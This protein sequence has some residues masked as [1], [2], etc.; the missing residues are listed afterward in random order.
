MM[1]RRL[2]I[3]V[4]IFGV[5]AAGLVAGRLLWHPARI[6][7]K[8]GREWLA[9]ALQASRAVAYEARG[10]VL[11]GAR[12]ASFTEK[13]TADGDLL[14]NYTDDAHAGAYM[15]ANRREVVVRDHGGA[16]TRAAAPPPAAGAGCPEQYRVELGGTTNLAGRRAVIVLVREP[17][18]GALL[19]RYVLDRATAVPLQTTTCLP[20]NGGTRVTTYTQITFRTVADAEVR[21]SHD[22]PTR[23]PLTLA[24]A[25]A[26]AGF[27]WWAPGWLPAGFTL[28]GVRTAPCPC[29]CSGG[30]IQATYRDGLQS[31]MVAE[32][33]ESPMPLVHDDGAT[34]GKAGR[35]HVCGDGN[36]Q[37]MHCGTRNLGG[38][39]NTCSVQG[40]PLV[41][42]NLQ[43][44]TII[45]VGE[46]APETL[47]RVSDSITPGAN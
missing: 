43:D 22:A 27:A 21:P 1:P 4:G 15:A 16:V 32:K 13:H 45:V 25:E 39:F 34:A 41:S 37:P 8:T 17:A 29:G 44:R 6:D 11:D 5:I 26:R 18:H 30:T 10:T 14:L 31:F 36:M 46:V 24:Q 33:K 2:L 9:Q 47:Q 38:C 19:A 42:R 35:R 40:A 7:G 28:A 3:L 20:R 12:A 23:Q